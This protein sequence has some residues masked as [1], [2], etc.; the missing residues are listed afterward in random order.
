MCG[1][2]A[3]LRWK[4]LSRKLSRKAESRLGGLRRSRAH[5]D[6]ILAL[7]LDSPG[8]WDESSDLSSAALGVGSGCEVPAGSEHP[9][10]PSCLQGTLCP[11][12]HVLITPPD[13]CGVVTWAVHLGL[14]MSR[15]WPLCLSHAFRPL[16]EPPAWRNKVSTPPGL[17]CRCRTN[18]VAQSNTHASSRGSGGQKLT[19]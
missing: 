14:L 5:P 16:P 15:V 2:R 18:I 11:I 1:L 7:T 10:L 12:C 17:V 19:G 9:R 3:E 4:T 8:T 6:Y 13:P